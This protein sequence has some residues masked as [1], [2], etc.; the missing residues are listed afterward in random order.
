LTGLSWRLRLHVL[1]HPPNVTALHP[2]WPDF[3]AVYA[4]LKKRLGRTDRLL[5]VSAAP[6]VFARWLRPL[7]DI[8]EAIEA[9]LIANVPDESST[10]VDGT[11]DACAY[12][13]DGEQSPNDAA[14]V[15][16]IKRMLKPVGCLV[17]LVS[18]DLDRLFP[19][20]GLD[21]AGLAWHLRQSGIR[22]QETSYV[23]AGPVRVALARAMAATMRAGRASPRAALPLLLAA[24]AL[25]A[26]AVLGCNL[27]IRSRRPQ[28][29]PRGNCSSIILTCNSPVAP[30]TSAIDCQNGRAY[31]D[32]EFS[33]LPPAGTCPAAAPEADLRVGPG[34][35][36][37]VERAALFNW[38]KRR[39]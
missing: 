5:V 32:P 19:D 1:G 18:A 39:G 26:G 2:R 30:A 15:N 16:R 38:E 4:T 10:A 7:C 13:I 23:P 27:L 11:F 17:V 36:A 21:L 6:L 24:G 33:A 9:E 3:Q 14:V 20:K 29:P 22:V 12:I 8:V 37:I 28:R 35:V 34:S 31:S 25:I